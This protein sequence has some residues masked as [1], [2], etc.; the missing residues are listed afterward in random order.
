M[1]LVFSDWAISPAQMA[2][3]YHQ[4]KLSLLG[5]V[6]HLIELLVKGALRIPK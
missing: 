3:S 6:Y 1:S 4:A 2:S 5:L